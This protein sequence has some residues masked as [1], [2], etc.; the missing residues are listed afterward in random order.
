MFSVIN[1][2]STFN[3]FIRSSPIGFKDNSLTTFPFG[4][5]TWDKI[6]ISTTKECCP[7][8]EVLVSILKCDH[9]IN[10]NMLT[11]GSTIVYDINQKTNKSIFQLFNDLNISKCE[12]IKLSMYAYDNKTG[13]PILTPPLIIQN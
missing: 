4:L 10:I 13:T 11:Y 8:I 3:F 12:H 2:T 9:N 1:F 7:D 5:P 6:I